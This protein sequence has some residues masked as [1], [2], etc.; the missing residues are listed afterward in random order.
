M[1]GLR[2]ITYYNK[3][4]PNFGK[5]HVKC[6]I[7]P[8]IHLINTNLVPN[9]IC[10][11]NKHS[12]FIIYRDINTRV[13]VTLAG[14]GCAPLPHPS[15]ACHS[16]EPALWWLLVVGNERTR[17][18]SFPGFHESRYIYHSLRNNLWSSTRWS[19]QPT[20]GMSIHLPC[21]RGH[22]W[23]TCSRFQLW[24]SRRKPCIG[25]RRGYNDTQKWSSGRCVPLPG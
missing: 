12:N 13:P 10:I 17:P 7:F 1:C 20:I 2:G 11:K 21:C 14:D 4:L 6:R 8:N 19:D 23:G 3:L 16:H 9:W 22:T 15:R 5:S 18:P 25:I 24:I